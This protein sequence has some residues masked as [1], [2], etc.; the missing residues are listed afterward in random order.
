[1]KDKITVSQ[2]K[3]IAKNVKPIKLEHKAKLEDATGHII[4]RSVFAKY[5]VPIAPLSAMDG[6]AVEAA[7]TTKASE[8]N[9]ITLTDF[10]RVNTGNAV[11][12]KYD[13]VI[14]VEDVEFVGEFPKEITISAPAKLGDN[15]RLTGEDIKEGELVLAAGAKI[16]PFDIG[17]LASYGVT[18]VYV[19]SLKVGV[20][21]TG[22]ELI[23]VGEVPKPGDV[24]ESNTVMVSSYLKEFGADV[25]RYDPVDDNPGTIRA[26]LT[27]A[28]ESNDIVLISAGSSMGSKDFTSSVI[29]EMGEL[30]FH[31]VFMKPAK[32]SMLGIIDG[33]PV[34]GLPGFPLSAQTTL[35]VIVRELLEVWGWKRLNEPVSVR[36][37]AGADIKSDSQLDEFGLAAVGKVGERYVALPQLRA[38]SIQMNAIRANSTVWIPLGIKK[39]STGEEVV[40]EI[41]VSQDELDRTILVS[42]KN[43]KGLQKIVQ[44]AAAGGYDLRFGAFDDSDGFDMLEK[45]Y[46]HAVCVKKGVAVPD[47]T[48]IIADFD[49][50][51][52][53]CK[54]DDANEPRVQALKAFAGGK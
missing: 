19:K 41:N 40:A 3:E 25:T 33:K 47:F 5:S 18:E 8:S 53:V 50:A 45:S 14:K 31:G 28:I 49:S 29:E 1:M 2:A 11:D 30:L 7:A 10:K 20:I 4:S 24:V 39:I 13:T 21:P 37:V 48:E 34:F 22:T 35:R 51:V 12:S 6:F 27:H 42:G 54:K 9:K 52:L 43:D 26:A 36:A 15:V 16:R 44:T 46:C 23:K 17:A 32:P 38:S